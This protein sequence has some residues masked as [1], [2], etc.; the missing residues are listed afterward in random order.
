[1]QIPSKAQILMGSGKKDEVGLKRETV[2]L[3]CPPKRLKVYSCR[4][5]NRVSLD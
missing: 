2:I 1:M 5:L 4:E 3:S